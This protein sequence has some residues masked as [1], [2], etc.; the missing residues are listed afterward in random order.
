VLREGCGDLLAED[1][2]DPG[3]EA[4]VGEGARPGDDGLV[5]VETPTSTF[6]AASE[7]ARSAMVTDE[8][9]LG[10]AWT[11][12][13]MERKPVVSSSRRKVR[14][15]SAPSTVTEMGCSMSS[16]SNPR[17]TATV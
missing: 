13:S 2:A 4:V 14:L 3:V 10:P 9:G 6:S 15:S 5:V 12:P 7:M 16:N 8:S 11:W 17:A 1:G